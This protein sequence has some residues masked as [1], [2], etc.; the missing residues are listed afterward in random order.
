MELL[1]KKRSQQT[2]LITKM[3]SVQCEYG[4]AMWNWALIN[5]DPARVDPTTDIVLLKDAPELVSCSSFGF[6]VSL[7][8]DLH[9]G[10]AVL[11]EH[12][13][14]RDRRNTDYHKDS[15]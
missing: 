13:P 1:M 14:G 2:V 4:M 3:A 5:V 10:A 11:R 7:K 15:S 8:C 12:R 9:V 6:R